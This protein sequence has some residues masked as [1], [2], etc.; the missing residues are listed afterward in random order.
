[1][2][3]EIYWEKALLKT[4]ISINSN[5]L[6]PLK[7]TDITKNIYKGNDFVIRELDISKFKKNNMD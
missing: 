3:K 4:K 6:F 5:S 2:N 1:M 7:T